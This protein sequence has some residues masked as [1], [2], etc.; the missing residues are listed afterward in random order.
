MIKFLSLNSLSIYKNYEGLDWDKFIHLAPTFYTSFKWD[1]AVLIVAYAILQKL[2]KLLLGIID[3]GV[4]LRDAISPTHVGT[5]TLDITQPSIS[6][7]DG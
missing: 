3:L 6:I 5:R 2:T 1:M 7:K 4:G